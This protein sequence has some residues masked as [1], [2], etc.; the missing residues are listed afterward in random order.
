[1]DGS[2]LYITVLQAKGR[3]ILGV[4]KEA[5][6]L[7][8]VQHAS[9]PGTMAAFSFETKLDDIGRILIPKSLMAVVRFQARE[10]VVIVGVINHLQIW[11]KSDWLASHEPPADD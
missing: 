2:K 1:M 11:K 3:K 8:A 4:F 5:A 7:E 6:W 10:E 9:E